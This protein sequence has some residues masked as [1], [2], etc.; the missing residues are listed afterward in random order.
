MRII[1]ILF[2]VILIPIAAISAIIR[3]EAE[4]Y[5]S[6]HDTALEPI[7]VYPYSTC[8]GGAMLVGLDYP[9]EWVTY[10]ISL[11]SYGIYEPS[12]RCRGDQNQTYSLNMEIT[13]SGASGPTQIINLN[14]NGK[15][16]G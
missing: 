2:I 4:D 7:R 11:S 8:S 1:S 13:P 14:F 6:S 12:I 16:Y 9:G 3:F 5:T 15:G 10:T